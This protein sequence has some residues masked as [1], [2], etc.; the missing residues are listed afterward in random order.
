MRIPRALSAFFITAALTLSPS[1]AAS[2][3]S[4]GTAGTSS[5]TSSSEPVPAPAPATEPTP[6]DADQYAAREAADG[7]AANFQGGNTRL[8]ISGGAVTLVLVIVILVIL[9]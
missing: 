6:S 8:Y 5:A 2:A 4:P 9:L 1:L 7:S 3:E